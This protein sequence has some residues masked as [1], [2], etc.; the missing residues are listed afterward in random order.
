MTAREMKKIV[1]ELSRIFD[2]RS[3]LVGMDLRYVRS[4]LHPPADE[5]AIAKFEKAHQP[6]PDSYRIFLSLHNGWENFRSGSTLIGVSGAHT[7]RALKQIREDVRIFLMKWDMDQRSSDPDF[8]A[9]Y[10]TKGRANAK[11]LDSAR[12]YLPNRLIFGIDGLGGNFFFNPK[13]H[14]QRGPVEVLCSDQHFRIR[15]RHADFADMLKA[16]LVFYREQL[17]A[18]R[19]KAKENR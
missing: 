11:T 16:D 2:E 12:I 10:E 8:I 17:A 3:S 13:S 9:R 14:G 7:K 6:F 4:T 19:K 5:D 1:E 18:Q 15:E